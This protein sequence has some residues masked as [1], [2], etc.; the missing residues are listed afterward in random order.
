MLLLGATSEASCRLIPATCYWNRRARA[1]AS[2]PFTPPSHT[3]FIGEGEAS[4]SLPLPSFRP[5]LVRYP[6]SVVHLQLNLAPYHC[7]DYN[8]IGSLLPN[9]QRQHCTLHI[10]QDV[11][12]NA[13]C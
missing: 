6:C 5:A 9:N 8:E 7:T 12:P 10:Q 4:L 2:I 11:L 13:L 3:C 1:W